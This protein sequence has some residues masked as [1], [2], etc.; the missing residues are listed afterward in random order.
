M[1]KDPSKRRVGHHNGRWKGGTRVNSDGYLQITAGPL[2]G[3]YVHR[4]VLEAKL[5][6]PLGENEETH[7]LNGDR[8]D[9]RPENLEVVKVEEHRSYLNGR[10]RWRKAACQTSKG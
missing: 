6:R 1:G 4:L 8:L 7:H 2:A 9:C 5:G 3:I 10:P